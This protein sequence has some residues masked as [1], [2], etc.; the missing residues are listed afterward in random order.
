MVNRLN[1][2]LLIWNDM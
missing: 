1:D 2:Y